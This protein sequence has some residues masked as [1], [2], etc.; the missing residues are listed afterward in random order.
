MVPLVLALVSYVPLLC[1]HPG[2]IGAD[3][4]QYLYLDPGRLLGRAPSMWEPNVGMGT[5]THQNIGYLLPMGPW[6]WVLRT[7][8]VPT[9]IAQRLWTGT[10][11]FLA[12]LGVVF[13]LRTIS[14]GPAKA[15]AD[16]KAL[17]RT[18]AERT[19]RGHFGDLALVVAG[20]AYA[21][22]PYVLEYEARISAI[23]MP[24]SALPWL[25][26]LV[27]RSLRRGGWRDPALF[28]ITVALCG[29]V[30]ATSLI[31]V[32]IAPILWIPHAVW[33]LREVPLRRALA[34]VGRIGVLTVAASLWWM[35]GLLTQAGYGLD[36]LRYTETVKVVA[37]TGTPIEV[38]R[39]LGNWYFYGRDTIAPWVQPASEYTQELWRI[40]VSLALPICALAAAVCIRWRH[41]IYFVSL[42]AVGMAIAVGV[43]PYAHPSPLGAVF[44]AIAN[45][46]SAGLAL[47]SVGRAVPLVALGTAVLLGAGVEALAVWRPRLSTA[48]GAMC[49]VLIALDMAPL[50]TGQFVDDSLQRP[51][52]LPSYLTDAVHALDSGPHDTRILELPGADFSHLRWGTTLDPVIPGL[53]DRPYVGR[54]LIPYGSA[55]SADL[56]RALDETLQEGVFEPSALAPLAR[57]MNVGDVVLR[58]DLQYERF[59]TPRPRPTWEQFS[60]PIPAGLQAP[61]AF[62]PTV[63]ER[64]VIP[65]TDEISLATPPSA[66]DPPAMAI[67]G[68]DGTA[69]IVHLETTA[70]PLI[71]A[72]DGQ[73]LV[74]AA[75]AGILDDRTGPVL[76]AGSMAGDPAAMRRALADGADLLLTDTNRRRGQR[77][78]TIRANNSYTEQA[79]ETPLVADPTDARLPLF[80]GAT[81]R[82]ATVAEQRGVASVRA[83]DYGNPVSYDAAHRPSQALDGDPTTAWTEGAFSDVNGAKLRIDLTSPVT[84]DHIGLVQP[85]LKPNERWITKATLIFDGV[86][87][88]SIVLGPESRTPAGQRVTFPTR[89]FRRLEI[90]VDDSNIGRR[91]DYRGGSGVGFSEVQIP[92]V[93]LDEILRLPTDVLDA[94]GSSAIDHRLQILLDRS[95]AQPLESF[96]TDP[97]LAIRRTF[98]LPGARSFALRGT[99]RLE[100]TA[101]DA[102][103]D[104]VLGRG[105]PSTV[106]TVTS[107]GHLPGALGSRAAAAVDGDPAT[108]W[109]TEFGDQ[110][111]NFIELHS[112]TSFSADHIDLRVVADGRHS[113]PTEVEVRVDGGA[114]Q[115]LRLPA[116]ADG[117]EPNASTQVRL[118]MSA[119]S[120][121]T[122]RVTI[123]GVREVKT[124][125]YFSQ[126]KQ[127]LPM[128]IAELVVPG[129]APPPK[130]ATT[131]PLAC[132]TDLLMIDG[133]P[134]PLLVSGQTSDA[135]RGAG[136]D[137]SLCPGTP[138]IQLGPGSHDV[139]TTPGRDSGIDLDRLLFA[140]ERGG[141]PHPLGPLASSGPEATTAGP[142][143]SS[144]GA[145][146]RVSSAPH[147]T[148]DPGTVKVVRKGTTSMRLQV[149]PPSSGESWL[150]LGQ[151]DNRGWTATV[152]RDGRRAAVGLG[153]SRLVDGYANGWIIPASLGRSPLVIDLVWTPQ[154][155]VNLA[156][157]ASAFALVVCLLLGFAPVRRRTSE[158]TAPSDG[159][160]SPVHPE[161]WSPLRPAGR[162]LGRRAGVLVVVGAGVISAVVIGP[163]AGLGV[164]IPVAVAVARP[165]WRGVISIGALALLAACA[166]YVLQLQYRY[167]FPAKI[168]WPD[169]FDRI[170]LLPWIAVAWVVVDTVVDVL[171]SRRRRSRGPSVHVAR[172]ME[173]RQ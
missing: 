10:L 68:V 125:N 62:G 86:A 72:G 158:W 21:L 34:A 106:T 17:P 162:P 89:T 128:A 97:E 12:G 145:V 155:T 9:W 3:T 50:F 61:R 110:E 43:H 164:A 49:L 100:S 92:G 127:P 33:G 168:E 25:V 48:A 66:P 150:V 94:A 140:S 11:L 109:Q 71:V 24:W 39:G 147:T 35:A 51:E 22:S 7:L 141:S 20:L 113:V 132:R 75:G 136:L 139:R 133:A 172:P 152:H 90:R 64:P 159:P 29:G 170:A 40:A 27:I 37:R 99:A 123:V 124:V 47:R 70:S 146:P 107:G 67:F 173:V 69:P 144:A 118:P 56:L 19:E 166:I 57:L 126:V 59:R 137:V 98:S 13:L 65:L 23:L 1:T 138:A 134:V 32:G 14:S 163:W 30:N 54:E 45:S 105:A 88:S 26:A 77:W 82:S 31:Y 96:V 53:T 129:I 160:S 153:S 149:T 154:R 114:P 121:T 112:P 83:T 95:R 91:A 73:G 18:A 15:G 111:G 41:K 87:G 38:L 156:L 55:A 28:A 169:H 16:A 36:V 135:Q 142:A 74:H 2:K 58:S 102:Q 8:G 120:G 60:A 4:K 157:V 81:D 46:S 6:Y 42:V 101:S 148:V 103:L 161:A 52:Q 116:V 63:L 78:G 122:I 79:G 5:V 130:L 171:R 165:R 143:G 104:A 115:R 93:T 84:T 117:A 167:R 85:L 151:S 119:V 131:L 76:Y 44:K 108:A 80:P